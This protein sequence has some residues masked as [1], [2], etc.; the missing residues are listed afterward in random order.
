[1]EFL[2]AQPF[3]RVPGTAESLDWALALVRLHRDALDE[4]R[5]Q[6]T[7]GCILKVQED[8]ELLRALRSRYVPLLTH[9][10]GDAGARLRARPAV[11]RDERRPGRRRLS[12]SARACEAS[13]ASTSARAKRTRRCARSRS[14]ACANARVSLPR[15]APICCSRPEEIAPFACAFDA[16]FRAKRKAFRSRDGRA[17]AA[18]R[19]SARRSRADRR[20]DRE[21]NVTPT[22]RA[23]PQAWQA[24][25]ARYSPSAAAPRSRRQFPAMGST[26]RCRKRTGWSRACAWG[27]RCAGSRSRAASA[28]ICGARCARACEPAATCSSRI[29][30]PSAAQ[31]ALRAA[32]R[33]QPL[34]ERIAPRDAAVSRTRSA[35]AR[36]VRRA[37][38]SAPSCAT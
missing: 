9:D 14:S 29:A 20:S 4:R 38:C 3:Q 27:V 23:A 17:R 2:R 11:R 6:Q 16:S 22:R 24:L 15:C 30:R 13:T 32:A 33:R 34:D 12:S 37:F 7:A 8:W 28:S 26:P 35:G 25:L 21:C 1:M 10:R 18:R 5:W 19:E 36:G 31:S